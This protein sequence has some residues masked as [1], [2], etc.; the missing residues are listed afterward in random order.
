[1]DNPWSLYIPAD[2]MLLVLAYMYQTGRIYLHN[3]IVI[4]DYLCCKYFMAV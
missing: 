4:F 1:M 2:T 3:N